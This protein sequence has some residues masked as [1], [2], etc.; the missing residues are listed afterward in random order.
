MPLAK[1]RF[2]THGGVGDRRPGTTFTFRVPRIAPATYTTY[3]RCSGGPVEWSEFGLGASTFKV[4][5]M[6]PDTSTPPDTSCPDHGWIPAVIS[7]LAGLAGA[8]VVD[9]RRARSARPA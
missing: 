6:A 5:P 2:R 7:L 3:S 1:G 8:I 4:D 9:R